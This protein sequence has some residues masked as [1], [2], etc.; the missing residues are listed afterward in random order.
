MKLP[1][2]IVP[3]EVNNSTYRYRD[4]MEM[5]NDMRRLRRTTGWTASWVRTDEKLFVFHMIDFDTENP[6]LEFFAQFEV[7]IQ[8]VH[9]EFWPG[10]YPGDPTVDKLRKAFFTKGGPSLVAQAVNE[11]APEPQLP[12]TLSAWSRLLSDDDELV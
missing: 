8:D 1:Q 9:R 3:A 10:K 4:A 11:T 5:M 7:K 2:T 12:E 6:D